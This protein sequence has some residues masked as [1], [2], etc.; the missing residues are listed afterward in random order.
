[1]KPLL[2]KIF[3]VFFIAFSF[4]SYPFDHMS[5]KLDIP[6]HRWSQSILL[7]FVIYINKYIYI[8]ILNNS[9]IYIYIYMCVS[10]TLQIK[11][12]SLQEPL[13]SS[14]LHFPLKSCNSDFLKPACSYNHLNNSYL[15]SVHYNQCSLFFSSPYLLKKVSLQSQPTLLSSIRQS[16]FTSPFFPTVISTMSI[17]K[18]TLTV[19]RNQASSKA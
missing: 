8:Y 9:Y 12:V 14:W 6:Y 17:K 1:M 16:L 3:V 18:P 5:Q 11:K 10:N 2:N 19:Q 4:T 15:Q 7:L 13:H